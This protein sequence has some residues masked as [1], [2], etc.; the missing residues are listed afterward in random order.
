MSERYE[1]RGSYE[2]CRFP[3]GLHEHK[4]NLITRRIAEKESLFQRKKFEDYFKKVSFLLNCVK[5]H[6]NRRGNVLKIVKNVFYWRK[7]FIW[8]GSNRTHDRSCTCYHIRW[9]RCSLDS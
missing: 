8:K 9:V 1:C 7:R 5:N 4:I 3:Q 6:Q 2:V